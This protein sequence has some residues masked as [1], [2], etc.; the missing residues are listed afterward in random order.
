[1]SARRKETRNKLNVG[2][3][4]IHNGGFALSRSRRCNVLRH[5]HTHT[6]IVCSHRQKDA[7]IFQRLALSM[8][9]NAKEKIALT[10]VLFFW[11]W[12]EASGGDDD[13]DEKVHSICAVSIAN[14]FACVAL[15][16][17]FSVVVVPFSP[18]FRCFRS[19]RNGSDINA[20]HTLSRALHAVRARAPL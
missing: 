1:M 18:H 8:H 10:F 13:D 19:R 16:D 9:A 2:V 5:A 7:S 11:S 4:C 20:I 14:T 3:Q 17:C 12:K 6:E 15:H